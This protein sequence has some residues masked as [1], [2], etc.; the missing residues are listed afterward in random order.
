MR[1]PLY[2]IVLLF[3]WLSTVKALAQDIDGDVLSL[4]SL[5][6]LPIN[7][8]SKSWQTV[9]LAPA[10]VTII[11]NRDIESFGY[12]TLEDVLRSVR[13]FY[14]SNDRNYSY[15]G[16]RGFSRPGDYNDRLLVL[17]N[18][19]YTNEHVYGS[20][21]YGY[22]FP[23]NF[24]AIERIEIV[25]G[26]GSVVYGTGA[27][28]AVINI[29]T[30]DGAEL[31]GMSVTGELG[32][33]GHKKVQ[34]AAG[35]TF[36]NGINAS[37]FT[38]WGDARGQDLYF[39]DFDTDSTDGIARNLDGTKY[40]SVFGRVEYG[41]LAV[42]GYTSYRQK[43]IPTASFDMVFNYPGAETIDRYSLVEARYTDLLTP[44]LLVTLRGNYNTYKYE[45][46]YVYPEPNPDAT[47]NKWFGTEAQ[48]Q[49]DIQPEHRL[50]AGI[51][52]Q[53]NLR[54][55][56]SSYF[57]NEVLF[58]KDVPFTVLSLYLQSEYQILENMNLTAGIRLDHHSQT[59]STVSPR[60]GIILNL[61]ALTTLKLLYGTGFRSPNFNEL[62]LAYSGTNKNN[63]GL[64]PEQIATWEAI[65]EQQIDDNWY[66]VASVFYNRM[67]NLIDQRIDAVDS[68]MQFRNVKGNNAV[69]GELELNA[70]FSSGFRGY[71]SYSLQVTKDD[72]G[73]ILSNS[74][75]HLLKG[76]VSNTFGE[77][78]SLSLEMLYESARQ[79][80]YNTFTEPYVLTNVL[81]SYRPFRQTEYSLLARNIFDTEY[82][83]PGGFEHRQ[84]SIPQDGRSFIAR[85]QLFF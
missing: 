32:S 80:V 1:V 40:Y 42:Q 85:I 69:G 3:F 15:I 78:L 34:A 52:Y 14:T 44:G 13:G 76:G 46:L 56:Y 16:I 67:T 6:T 74:P 70:R 12:H 11:T 29:I 18:G 57:E 60:G 25:R 75:R 21:A 23:L 41:N 8:V 10:S 39:P 83:L 28:F 61:T 45:G 48:V 84:N 9:R 35:K 81:V 79:T 30:K 71:G 55:N 20:A 72:D 49:W 51:E 47:T 82:T 36:D 24:D 59:G 26:P 54:A 7:T 64:K 77:T 27:M 73:D 62:Y 63:P 50:S 4:D 65:A 43:A 22:D 33:F 66:V 31:N 2:L 5:L 58:D 17:L 19:H 37:M 38:I 53:N 68:L